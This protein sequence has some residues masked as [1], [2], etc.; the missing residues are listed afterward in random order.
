ME[1]NST[2]IYRCFIIKQIRINRC[3]SIF[4]F[5]GKQ[6]CYGFSHKSTV[7]ICI[8]KFLIR[9]YFCKFI[10]NFLCFIAISVSQ[11][12]HGFFFCPLILLSIKN[13]PRIVKFCKC[14]TDHNRNVCCPVTVIFHDIFVVNRW[15]PCISTGIE[16]DLST[17]FCNFVVSACSGSYQ[18]CIIHGFEFVYLT[19]IQS[20]IFQCI[21]CGLLCYFLCIVDSSEYSTFADNFIK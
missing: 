13:V 14:R 1:S 9:E 18:I 2:T 20:E 17:F 19:L 5:C 3:C 12:C 7:E 16:C 11:I 10:C 4:Q 6:F 15:S 21:S 8:C